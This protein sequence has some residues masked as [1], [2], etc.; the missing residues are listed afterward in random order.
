MHRTRF[1]LLS[2]LLS[3][4]LA[5]NSGGG[6]DGG[7]SPTGTGGAA[8]APVNPGNVIFFR[9]NAPG[10]G[11]GSLANPFN[12]LTV[13][14]AAGAGQTVFVFAGSG[15]PIPFA[16]AFPVNTTVIGE[17]EGLAA[18]N[19]AAG[20]F[21]RIQG[22]LQLGAGDVVRGLGFENPG[23]DG[24]VGAA[25]VTVRNNRFTNLAGVGLQFNGLQGTVT[26]DNNTFADDAVTNPGVGVLV[27]SAQTQNLV[28]NFTNNRFTTPDRT[29]AFDD[30][31]RVT[32]TD[33]AQVTVNASGNSLA[34]QA[35][36][37][38]LRLSATAS[39]T[40]VLTNNTFIGTQLDAISVLAGSAATDGVS[41]TVTVRSNTFTSPLGAGALLR[42]RGLGVHNWTIEQNNVT[43]GGNFGLLFVRN[44]TATVRATVTNNTIANAA[45]VGL[46]YTSGDPTGGF[47]VPL[48]GEDRVILSNN[49]ISGSGV[50]AIAMSM[51]SQTHAV[52]L[53]GNTTANGVAVLARATNACFGAGANTVGGAMAVTVENGFNLT[54]DDRGQTTP[55]VT[56]PGLG[57]VMAGP[58][59][60]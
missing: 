8:A 11:D 59:N 55:A 48:N 24:V 18:A 53:T 14:L 35:S 49:Q 29:A 32:A 13:A 4:L 52:L 17:G 2:T 37:L 39:A 44:D 25:G 43:A 27:T 22:N 21:P 58:C 40:G 46:Q 28:V 47:A 16:G 7:S 38:S 54:F 3:L 45:Q 56:F 51:I 60:P 50:S 9:D 1:L 57:T 5:C 19:V 42:A 23:G 41:S 26:I 12:N 30:G 31:L 36:G 15:N 6:S 10:G 33:S 34:T 20:A